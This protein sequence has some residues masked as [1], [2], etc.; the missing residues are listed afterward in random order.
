[1]DG[2]YHPLS[3]NDRLICGVR[4][5]VFHARLR[6]VTTALF[7]GISFIP[8]SILYLERQQS[9]PQ[10][11]SSNHHSAP[12]QLATFEACSINSFLS[13]GL[14][15]LDSASPLPVS[16]F[17]TRRNNL[18]KALVSDGIDAFIVEPGYTFQYYA[19]VSQPTWEVWEP[20]ERP[21]LMI[22]QPSYSS[23]GEIQARTRFLIPS[24]EVRRAQ[25]LNMPLEGKTQYI[26]WEEHWNPYLT[27][28]ESWD[29]EGE[30]SKR[31]KPKVMVDD[32]M[33][34]FIQ[35]GLGEN[36]FEVVGL[37]GEVENVKQVKTER[38]VGILRAV[39]TGTV[40]AVRAM[41]GCMYLGLREDEVKG[42]LDNTLRAGGLEPFFDIVLFDENA[43]N[44]H[45]GTNG[46]KILE[47]TTFV[48]IDVGAHLYGYSSDICRTFF[49][50]QLPQHPHTPSQTTPHSSLSLKLDIWTLVLTAQSLA[51][52][53]LHP[54]TPASLPDLAARNYLTSFGYGAEFTHRVGHGIGI[55]AHES[56]YLHQGNNV[57]VLRAGMVFTLEPGVYLEGRFGVRHEDV[58]LVREGGEAECLSGRRAG[59]AWDP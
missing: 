48:L 51:L 17:V 10:F 32:E 45:G 53:H 58:F 1:M 28:L 20:E 12:N 34:D 16:E 57:S 37:G 36:G 56:P 54:S 9:R 47:A 46:S 25:L 33:R 38:E 7:I 11:P 8:L 22:I 14:P 55:K 40:E 39:N 30:E 24:F 15:F 5:P 3:E 19:N 50:P 21:F 18:A 44:P 42:V 59:G 41:R 26:A 31:K 52:S 29:A 43:A 23:T 35:R 27:L 49:P 13:T 2:R 4:A 6:R